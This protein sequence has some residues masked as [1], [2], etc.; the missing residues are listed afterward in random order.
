MLH[1]PRIAITGMGAVS[2]FGL[3]IDALAKG[4]RSGASAIRPIRAFDASPYRV[5][6]MAEAPPDSELPDAVTRCDA[7]AIQASRDAA[8]SAGIDRGQ[9]PAGRTAVLIGSSA[10]GTTAVER[11]RREQILGH[12]NP[13]FRGLRGCTLASPGDSVACDLGLSGPRVAVST[14]CSSSAVSIAIAADMIRSG[15]AE[16]A[17]A[18]GVE[19]VSEFVF[20]GFHSLMALDPESCRPFDIRRRGLVLGEAAAV[21]VMESES[22]ARSRG[23]RPLAILAGYGLCCD[24]HHITAPEPT[25]REAARTMNLALADAGLSSRNIDHVDAHGTA[26][27]VGDA[28]EVRGIRTVFEKHLDQITVSGVKGALGHTLG[29]AGG[30]GIVASVLQLRDGVVFPTAGLEEVDPECAAPH[31]IARAR[32]TGPRRVL[33]SA[34]SFG[35]N[36]IATVLEAPDER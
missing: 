15:R 24:T 12:G 17:I 14:A 26:T 8:L 30:L 16:I 25:G 22:R 36:N 21:V 1:S 34:F 27:P 3:G 5:G 10:G 20:A 2:G 9:F 23:H 29:A 11:L 4:L 19:A 31:V 28:A 13:D 33:S 7:L 18:G 6:I 35:G 32:P